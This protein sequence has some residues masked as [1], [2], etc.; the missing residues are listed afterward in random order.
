[1]TLRK[2]TWLAAGVLAAGMLMVFYGTSSTLILRGFTRLE[3]ESVRTNI[4]RA[5][6]ALANELQ[7]LDTTTHDWARWDDSYAFIQN[8]NAA[9][10][11][12]SLNEGTLAGIRVDSIIYMNAAGCVVYTGVSN[13]EGKKLL[14]SLNY[15]ASF[16]VL[17]DLSADEDNLTGIVLL[18]EGP[19]MFAA[20]PILTSKAEGP[21]RGVLIMVRQLDK[22]EVESIGTL[23]EVSLDIHR[24]DAEEPSEAPDVNFL[25]SSQAPYHV[26]ESGETIEGCTLVNDLLGKPALLMRVEMPR[27]IHAQAHRTLR[28]YVLILAM[29]IL[30][31]TAV[32]V[33]LLEKL[34]LSRLSSLRMDVCRIA[35][36]PDSSACV[37]VS[38]HDELSGVA[39]SVN[40]LLDALRESEA[41]Y[42]ALVDNVGIGIAL[43]N[44]QMDVLSTNR[45]MRTWFPHFDLAKGTPSGRGRAGTSIERLSFSG[46]TWKTLQDGQVHEAITE[47]PSGNDMVT[48]K[49]VSS[50]LKDKD[51]KIVAAIEMLS[52]ITEEKK[53]EKRLRETQEMYWQI[54][55]SITDLVVS[56]GPG[57]KIIWANK[58]YRDYHKI[59][60]DVTESQVHVH[61]KNGADEEHMFKTGENLN[62]PEEPITRA[63]GVVRVFHTIKSP[64]FN[65]NSH[66]KLIV[67]VSRDITERLRESYE[68]L[69]SKEA[70]EA[71]AEAKSAFLANMSHEIRTPMNGVIGM[72]HLLLDTKLDRQQQDFAEVI[73]TSGESLLTVINDIL[74]FSKIEAGKL[75]LEHIDFDLREMV[76]NAIEPLA[77][78]AY[79]KRIEL[80]NSSHP[81]LATRFRG[82]PDRVRQVLLNLASNAVKFT[83]RG[84]VVVSV[85]CESETE[86]QAVIRFEVSDTGIGMPRE[87]QMRLFQPF[88]QADASTTRRFGGTGLGLAISRQLVTLMHGKIGVRSEPGKGSTFWFSIP[89]QKSQGVVKQSARFS[90]DLVNVRVLIVDDNQTNRQIL[91]HQLQAWKMRS[92]HAVNAEEA[93]DCLRAAVAEGDPY[94]LAILD[95]QMPGMDGLSLARVVKLDPAIAATRLIMLTSLGHSLS[96]EELRTS[97]I[98][99]CLLKPVKQSRFFNCL[100]TILSG[101]SAPRKVSSKPGAPSP[102]G[103]SKG[104]RILLAEDNLINQKVALSQLEKLGYTADVVDNGLQALE[105]L[106]KTPYDVVLMD[107][108]MPEMD[109]Y[110]ATRKIR[111]MEK[112]SAGNNGHKR[113]VYIIAMTAHAMEGDRETCHAAGMDNYLSKPVL[114]EDLK[115]TLEQGIQRSSQ[116]GGATR[117][118]AQ[119]V[120]R[121]HRD[122]AETSP[123]VDM[124]RFREVASGNPEQLQKLIELYISQTEE[125]VQAMEEA[126]R[127][128]SAPEI[129][130]LAHKCYGSSAT[131][132]VNTMV[133]LLRELEISGQEGRMTDAAGLVEKIRIQF[134]GVRDFL[135]GSLEQAV[136][137]SITGDA[138]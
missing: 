65:G 134:E 50:A 88:T 56:K 135:A 23:A 60:G 83:E 133:G 10:I 92:G 71:A 72:T 1:M 86:S 111:E 74:D 41:K 35:D 55:D 24:L 28:A 30:L 62:I 2:K 137:A 53:F 52:D 81:E 20:R 59:T 5:R 91:K 113:K 7:G 126:C 125:I 85:T 48:Y 108:Q 14:T 105:A 64:I 104:T 122:S 34:V 3:A 26:S 57:S 58:A 100:V 130:R 127:A 27:T 44:P 6:K 4:D 36:D 82:D 89:L 129:K 124:V 70:A 118:L 47:V 119:R 97:G 107:C 128:G 21:S 131:C 11:G 68:L 42:K 116:R 33:W 49:V 40:T 45:Q 78:Q 69:K 106:E 77:A 94:E 103:V 138:A 17:R 114:L 61:E 84:E 80:A 37:S 102:L 43:I 99:D 123:L 117:P 13:P 136:G 31:G 38:G 25:L 96:Q 90:R 101:E 51:G 93:L 79:A 109:G 110:E 121:A 15:L 54:L 16:K 76:E 73:R 32:T 8:T 115:K 22:V 95:M 66:V 19:V 9:Y 120:A 46:P 12:S 87:V 29:F 67:S 18:P 112:P 75:T 98:E 132:G 39:T 63:D